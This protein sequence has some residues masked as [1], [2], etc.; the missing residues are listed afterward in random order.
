MRPR[1]YRKVQPD[2]ISKLR[3]PILQTIIKALETK[4]GVSGE[5]PKL[6]VNEVESERMESTSPADNEA[7][8]D[9]KESK[10]EDEPEF[11]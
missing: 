10:S 11:V 7:I 4:L 6:E 9:V 3:L 2:P 5:E 8:E 1:N